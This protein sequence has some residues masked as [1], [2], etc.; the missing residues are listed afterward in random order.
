MRVIFEPEEFR[1]LI[2]LQYLLLAI[3]SFFLFELTEESTTDIP[4]LL[5]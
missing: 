1:L 2:Q 3:S 4:Q 5:L